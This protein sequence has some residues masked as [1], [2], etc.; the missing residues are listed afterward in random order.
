MKITSYELKHANCVYHVIQVT[1]RAQTQTPATCNKQIT[2]FQTSTSIMQTA[3]GSQS[4]LTIAR[5]FI[6]SKI[7]AG[8]T[9]QQH[10]RLLWTPGTSNMAL[11]RTGCPTI[12]LRVDR[13]I[14]A[15]HGEKTLRLLVFPA[16]LIIL[17]TPTIPKW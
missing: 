11:E 16:K 5:G 4:S 8:H 12:D 10:F 13:D 17:S 15:I 2:I 1:F 9:H 3:K 6:S 14:S 7:Y